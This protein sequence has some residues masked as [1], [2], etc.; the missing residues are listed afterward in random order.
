MKE[1]KRL[2]FAPRMRVSA[3]PELTKDFTR[4]VLNLDWAFISDESSLWDFH[5]DLTNEALTARIKE[6]Y[7]VDVTD[8]ES[9]KL[10]EILDRIAKETVK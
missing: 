2:E 7:G 1:P 5:E 8:I 10:P 3:H 9:A 4:R 6:I